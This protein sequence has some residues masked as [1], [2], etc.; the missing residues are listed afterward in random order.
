MKTRKFIKQTE[1]EAAPEVVFAFHEQPQ[2]I[3]ALLPP[4]ERTAVIQYP[5]DIKVG[6]QTIIKTY[7]GPFAQT[8]EAEHT[9]YIANRL[10][11]DV[12]RKGP[13]A[14]WQHRHRFE[15]TANG[16]TMMIDEIEYALPLGW[17]GNL[18]GGALVKAKLQKVFDYRHQVLVEKFNG[19]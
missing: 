9:E 2:A 8:W 6:A 12:Q 3:S 17:L 19:V 16:T 18:I 15:P 7:L 1:L 10:F 11:V 14:Y 13:F 5:N 4:W